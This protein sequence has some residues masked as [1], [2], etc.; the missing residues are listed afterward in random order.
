MIKQRSRFHC[1]KIFR[2]INVSNYTVVLAPLYLRG[3]LKSSDFHTAYY[4][5]ERKR[6][7]IVWDQFLYLVPLSPFFAPIFHNLSISKIS[8][9][10][11]LN[12]LTFQ[13]KMKKLNFFWKKMHFIVTLIHKIMRQ[14]KI[15]SRSKEGSRTYFVRLNKKKQLC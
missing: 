1:F 12:F 4:N 9:L 14:H 3:N 13:E 11:M 15:V 8:V 7:H 10:V 2:A 5:Y 6:D